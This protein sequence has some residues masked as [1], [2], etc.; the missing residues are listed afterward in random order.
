MASVSHHYVA[1]LTAAAK[2]RDELDTEDM[3]PE[4]PQRSYGLFGLLSQWTSAHREARV[5]A[6]GLK[7]AKNGY[8]FYRRLVQK[9]EPEILS[10]GLTWRRALLSP[11]FPAKEAEFQAALEH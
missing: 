5:L 7:T 6:M 9:M 11:E 4:T 8:E 3:G 10:K 1:E 2:S